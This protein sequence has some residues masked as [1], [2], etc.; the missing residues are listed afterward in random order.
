MRFL[1]FQTKI[2]DKEYVVEGSR[3]SYTDSGCD[4]SRSQLSGLDGWPNILPGLVSH[5]ANGPTM[6]PR[7]LGAPV[8]FTCQ[9]HRNDALSAT[10]ML[11]SWSYLDVGRHQSSNNLT[12]NFERSSA[13]PFIFCSILYTREKRAICLKIHVY[14]ADMYLRT[15]DFLKLKFVRDSMSTTI[16]KRTMIIVEV[17]AHLYRKVSPCLR[18][19]NREIVDG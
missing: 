13:G 8:S 9:G 16:R 1:L 2:K 15:R 11:T 18:R 5:R 14:A 6:T 3:C 10:H 12:R 4:L 7:T 17:K 19:S